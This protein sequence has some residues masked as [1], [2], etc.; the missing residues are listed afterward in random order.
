MT[1]QRRPGRYPV[2]MRERAVRMVLEHQHEYGSQ[3]EAICSEAS[4]SPYALHIWQGNHGPVQPST[5]PIAPSALRVRAPPLPSDHLR[6][7]GRNSNRNACAIPGEAHPAS[8]QVSF[9]STAC[10]DS[11][12]S[13]GSWYWSTCSCRSTTETLRLSQVSVSSS[14]GG[15]V[16]SAVFRSV[17]IWVLS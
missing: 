11:L 1:E 12:G 3:W 6:P 10:R 7:P 13:S 9:S 5:D 16:T 14:A 17:P 4:A 2:E 8:A 15:M